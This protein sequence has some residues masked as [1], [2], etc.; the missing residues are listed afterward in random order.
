[1]MNRQTWL[2]TLL[3]FILLPT[4]M[5]IEIYQTEES[6]LAS[7][8]GRAENSVNVRIISVPE[9]FARIQLAINAASDRDI[10]FVGAGTYYE[11]LVL[12]KSI[13]LLGTGYPNTIVDANRTADVIT[14]SANNAVVYGFTFQN[15][16]LTIPAHYGV[17]I[18]NVDNVLVYNNFI[19]GN[20][21]GIKLGDKQRGSHGNIIKTNIVTK[22]RY[23][24]FVDHSSENLFYGNVISMNEWNGIEIAWSE[25]NIF[26]ANTISYNRAYGLEIV[27]R[28]PARYNIFSH[29]NF[30]NNTKKVSI[31]NLPNVWDH[32]YPSG[33]NYWSD[34]IAIDEYSGP[35][36]NE[37]GS[38]GIGDKPYA[39]DSNNHDR[40][41]LVNSFNLPVP[42]A[43]NFVFSP[44]LPHVGEK[45]TFNASASI[46]YSGEIINYSWNFG[47]GNTGAGVTTTHVYCR[48][49]T[50]IVFLN[51]TSSV[52]WSIQT[53]LITIH[54][55][56]CNP[57]T[58]IEYIVAVS[59]I[60][61]FI[62]VTAAYFVK[63]R[64]PPPSSTQL[65]T[66]HR[67]R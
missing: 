26:Q 12:N 2:I 62:V 53:K 13:L 18:D 55:L 4:F 16:G 38:D 21:V 3:M 29:N 14:I 34:Y 58:N 60:T 17:N 46:P 33:G 1:M 35:N 54:E 27:D 6:S 31:S 66:S 15:G 37:L 48:N 36:Q 25:R 20:F 56:Q 52:L 49:G 10:V 40:Y 43:V 59:L 24:I 5:I 64:K 11:S 9:D 19:S 23:G 42:P 30:I 50:F 39:I 7:L 41:P 22:N 67:T 45:I 44:D 51:V 57:F 32:G 61:A 47:D 8:N 63:I 65:A 28:T